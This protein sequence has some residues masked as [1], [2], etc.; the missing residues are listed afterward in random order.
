MTMWQ[1]GNV[2]KTLAVCGIGLDEWRISDVILF[3]YKWFGC[4][5]IVVM[6]IPI[7]T[8]IF[9]SQNILPPECKR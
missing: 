3:S 9:T 7:D 5:A 4:Y 1:N 2:V 8:H 6:D